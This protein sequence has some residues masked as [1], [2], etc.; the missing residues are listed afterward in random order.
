MSCCC[1]DECACQLS[2]VARGGAAA[3]TDGG[4]LFSYFC[5]APA[6]IIERHNRAVPPNRL[7]ALVAFSGTR[8]DS[9]SHLSFNCN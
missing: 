1:C 2:P 6:T 5:Q 9:K 8:L 4:T 3:Q 7:A